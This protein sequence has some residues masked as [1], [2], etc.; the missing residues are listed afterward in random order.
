M[1]RVTLKSGR[2]LLHPGKC[3]RIPLMLCHKIR[4][5]MR[6]TI[7]DSTLTRRL[8]NK[9]NERKKLKK[10][11]RMEREREPNEEEREVARESGCAK[12]QRFFLQQSN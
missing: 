6:D 1:G 7:R 4:Q 11:K 9:K 2:S 5:L 8:G 10:S 3:H 12:V